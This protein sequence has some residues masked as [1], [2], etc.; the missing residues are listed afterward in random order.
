MHMFAALIQALTII[1]FGT[2]LI[3]IKLAKIAL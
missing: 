1:N 2:A 3:N